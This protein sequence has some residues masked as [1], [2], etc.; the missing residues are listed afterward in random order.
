[1]FAKWN[2]NFCKN[3]C[4]ITKRVFFINSIPHYIWQSNSKKNKPTCYVNIGK[5]ER[6]LCLKRKCWWFVNNISISMA[7][8]EV[9]IN[10]FYHICIKYLLNVLV[11]AASHNNISSN[12]S[13]DI[14]AYL[15]L[16]LF[17]FL[18]IFDHLTAIY[19]LLS[20]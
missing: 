17:H 13:N 1:M 20:F 16:Y 9:M 12:L 7:R 10:I 14:I 5:N 15:Y 4:E 11:L 18:G 6:Y 19:I 2:I 3:V 8:Y